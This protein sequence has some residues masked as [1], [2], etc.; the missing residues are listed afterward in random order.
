MIF[1][2]TA[3]LND[4]I[5]ADKGMKK[6]SAADIARNWQLE[7][8]IGF[9]LRLL[10]A[11]Y[12]V[13]YQNL[14][15]Q[16][17]ITPRQFGVLIALYQQGP[18]TPSVL[19]EHISCDRKNDGA[20]ADCKKEQFGR[21]AIYSSSDHGQGR[22][23]TFGRCPRRCRTAKHDA[24]AFAQGRSRAFSQVHVGYRK[25]RASLCGTRGQPSRF[26]FGLIAHILPARPDMPCCSMATYCLSMISAQTRSAFV[27]RENRFPLFRIMLYRARYRTG[28][29]F[30]PPRKDVSVQAG[31]P[32]SS[33]RSIR[34]S[35]SRKNA[36][37]S[38]LARCLPMHA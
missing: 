10:E 28:S 11:R 18:L 27:A 30:N 36:T 22:A 9:L 6:N 29:R 12:D 32:A 7:G 8:G 15:A 33:I 20:E 3:Q 16:S 25:S 5:S 1:R 26:C 35:N 21:P 14:T 24:G 4:G 17:D 34:L 13:L 23:S 38:A 31:S 37:I 19:P 2:T